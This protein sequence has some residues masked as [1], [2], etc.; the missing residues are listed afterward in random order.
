MQKPAY[1]QV[2]DFQPTLLG[3]HNMDSEV[4]LQSG[5]LRTTFAPRS[6]HSQ[7]SQGNCALRVSIREAIALA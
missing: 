1:T 4:T 6:Q 2:Y 5:Q 7:Y 3:S